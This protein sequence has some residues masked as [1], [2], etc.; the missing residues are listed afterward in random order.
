VCGG[1]ARQ[2][3]LSL[4]TMRWS[5]PWSEQNES[6]YRP[7]LW[8]QCLRFD[9][10]FAQLCN[11]TSFFRVVATTMLC[12][13][14][15]CETVG[16]RYALRRKPEVV[17][18]CTRSWPTRWACGRDCFELELLAVHD[19]CNRGRICACTRQEVCGLSRS[20]CFEQ[21]CTHHCQSFVLVVRDQAGDHTSAA[22][23]LR[24]DQL[25]LAR[26]L[27]SPKAWSADDARRYPGQICSI[28]HGVTYRQ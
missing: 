23:Y 1:A 24:F 4:T 3:C 14:S 19:R 7:R 11:L 26:V 10:P 28:C 9:S 21:P 15:D 27:G 22:A 16:C 25:H 13:W 6:C 2:L 8:Q 12:Y 17:D 5:T 18:E 20:D